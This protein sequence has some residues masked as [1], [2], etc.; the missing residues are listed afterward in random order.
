MEHWLASVSARNLLVSKCQTGVYILSNIQCSRSEM[1]I[2]MVLEL[3]NLIIVLG[4][5]RASKKKKRL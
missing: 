3:L 2:L 5:V 1:R 4:E